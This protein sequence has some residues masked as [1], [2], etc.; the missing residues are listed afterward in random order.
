M[1]LTLKMTRLE[2]PV[3]PFLGIAALALA[4]TGLETSATNWELV[5]AAAVWV[6]VLAAVA[7]VLPW[8]SLPPATVLVLPR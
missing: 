6:A 3:V 5:V 8:S 2:R 4:A 7:A 1:A